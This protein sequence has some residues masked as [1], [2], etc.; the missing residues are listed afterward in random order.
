MHSLL[1]L[2]GIDLFIQVVGFCIAY[3]LQTEK[4][5]DLVG[6]LTF[7]LLTHVSLR[8]NLHQN[9]RRTLLSFMVTIWALR[10]GSFL[11]YRCLKDGGDRR[12][13]KVKTKPV[14]F[15]IYWTVQALWIYITLFPV[16][17]V[18]TEKKSKPLGSIDY[19]GFAVWMLG[20]IIEVTADLQKMAF[21]SNPANEGKFISEG[22]WSISRHPN[23]FGEIMLWIG[24]L[25]IAS[26]V[27]SGWKWIAVLSPVFIWYLLN[28]VSGIPILERSGMKRYGHLPEYKH[29]VETVPVLTPFVGSV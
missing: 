25:I 9:W 2:A 8:S 12:F 28:Y 21:R 22:V 16:L 19:F 4:F 26:S 29:Y 5:Y 15:F 23:Y 14:V 13:T 3:T 7:I 24:V 18:N 17:L 20:M 27:L 11:C 10:L 1:T 6:S